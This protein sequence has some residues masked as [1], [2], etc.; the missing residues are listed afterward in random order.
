MH[1]VQIEQVRIERLL[2]TELEPVRNFIEIDAH[3]QGLTDLLEMAS[4]E[5]K[6]VRQMCQRSKEGAQAIHFPSPHW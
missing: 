5:T 4:V 1:Q 2:P 3:K 6:R